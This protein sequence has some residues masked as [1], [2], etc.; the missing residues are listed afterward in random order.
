MAGIEITRAAAEVSNSKEDLLIA[1]T[2]LA[3]QEIVLKNALSRNGLENAWLDEVRIVPLDET[4]H[5]LL[6]SHGDL[7][8]ARA[9]LSGAPGST[10]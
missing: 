8:K 1:Q 9:A 2:N 7:E 6:K 10:G 3:Q 4:L 5:V